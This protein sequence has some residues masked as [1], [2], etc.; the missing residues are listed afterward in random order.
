MSVSTSCTSHE[1]EIVGLIK[2]KERFKWT[3]SFS[4]L[5]FVA[6]DL[7]TVAFRRRTSW[8]GSW[9]SVGQTKARPSRLERIKDGASGATL[10]VTSPEVSP[11]TQVVN[12]VAEWTVGWP[13]TA[14]H[15]ATAFIRPKMVMGLSWLL[16][17][18]NERL[19]LQCTW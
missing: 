15:N 12:V 6:T 17:P 3:T 10:L 1:I 9:S 14:S 18:F 13:P 11:G 8:S 5:K 2:F 7:L 19:L 16:L 4:V